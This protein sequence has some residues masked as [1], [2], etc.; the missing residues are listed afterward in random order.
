MN[1][2]ITCLVDSP[3]LIKSS[4]TYLIIEKYCLINF[5]RIFNLIIKEFEFTF[6]F[7]TIFILIFLISFG[8]KDFKEN[9][10]NNLHLHLIDQLNFYL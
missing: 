6:K 9:S 8:L 10:I 2:L 4:L 5:S 7:Y 3:E 1:R